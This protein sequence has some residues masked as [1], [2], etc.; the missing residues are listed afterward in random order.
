MFTSHAQMA[1]VQSF[2]VICTSGL[3]A[4]TPRPVSPCDGSWF[5]TQGGGVVSKTYEW[6]PLTD[7]LLLSCMDLAP[8]HPAG[9]YFKL[10][11]CPNIAAK[12]ER[13]LLS[14]E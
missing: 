5:G 3:L 1:W 10:I 7:A 4:L 11:C 6:K 2:K 13:Q 9:I 14:F 8:P 12:N